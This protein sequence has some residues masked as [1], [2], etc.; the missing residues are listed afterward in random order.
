MSNSSI[1]QFEA[2]TLKG[3]KVRLENYQGKTLL[4][5]NTA[6]KCGLTPQYEGLE[7]LYQKYHAQ[8][9]EILGFPCNQ[10]AGQEPGSS[11]DIEEFCSVNYGVSFPMFAKVDVNGKNA[12]PLFKHLKKALPGT[13]TNA[14]KW[15]FTK[16]L[17]DAQGNPVKRFAPT[18]EPLNME[19][20]IQKTLG[21]A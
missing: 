9:L 17:I 2:E 4:I 13:L 20:D 3:E 18:T 12:H 21:H 7:E 5:V 14:I 1:Y 10:F 15:N 6:S 8:G 19:E 11:A 16:F